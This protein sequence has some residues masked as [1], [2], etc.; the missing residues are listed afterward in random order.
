M[1]DNRYND[2]RIKITVNKYGKLVKQNCGRKPK[3][4]QE[5]VLRKW[6]EYNRDFFVDNKD[7][8]IKAFCKKEEIGYDT[9]RRMLG[10]KPKD[11]L[12]EYPKKV[13]IS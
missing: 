9:M 13:N 12:K 1:D 10:R 3:Y 6:K 4:D 7:K 5:E 11:S 2:K 8:T